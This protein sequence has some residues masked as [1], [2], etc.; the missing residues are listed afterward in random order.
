MRRRPR[1]ITPRSRAGHS[2][3]RTAN[4]LLLDGD[5]GGGR[6]RHPNQF[7]PTPTLADRTKEEDAR[8]SKVAMVTGGTRGI[9]RAIVGRLKQDGFSVAA[10]YAC[11]EDAAKACACELD[12]MTVRGDV[13]DFEDCQRAVSAVE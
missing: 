11:N 13:S 2:A 6:H 4:R 8:M 1:S 9:G 5:Q 12:V 3:D 10:G 7:F